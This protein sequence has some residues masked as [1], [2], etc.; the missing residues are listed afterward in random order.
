MQ[1]LK[2]CFSK[3]ILNRDPLVLVQVNDD[4]TFLI[5]SFHYFGIVVALFLK[6]SSS[7]TIAFVACFVLTR[8]IL[9]D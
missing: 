8:V 7:K 2:Y 1:S 4:G 9:K 6:L 5:I 3:L